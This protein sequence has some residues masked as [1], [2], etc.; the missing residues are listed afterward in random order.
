MHHAGNSS[1]IVDGAAL[2]LIVA[3]EAAGTANGLTPRAPGSCPLRCPAPT[4]RSC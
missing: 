1:G 4:R 3:L 2:T